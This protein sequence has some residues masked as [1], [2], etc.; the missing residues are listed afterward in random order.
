MFSLSEQPIK[1]KIYADGIHYYLINLEKG[2][3]K[4]RDYCGKR[5]PKGD[6]A[7]IDSIE[8]IQTIK[9]LYLSNHNEGKKLINLFFIF[10]YLF[11]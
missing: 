7:E 2:V 3:R 1:T 8:K 10:F 4:A 11:I 5:F 6:L 9:K